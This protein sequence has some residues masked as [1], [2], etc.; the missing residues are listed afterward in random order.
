MRSVDSCPTAQEC[1][2]LNI[3]HIEAGRYLYGGAAQVL[4]LLKGLRER[5]GRQVLICAQGSAI[6]ET[7]RSVAD[8][9]YAV[10][11][12]GDADVGL[13]P[14]VRSILRCERADLVHLH[15]RRGADIWGALAARSCGLP[16][17]L[18]RRVDHPEP[19]WLAPW[20]YRLYDR[21]IA[22]SQGIRQ[23]LVQHGAVS[24]QQV[25]CVCSAVDTERFKPTGDHVWFRQEFNLAADELTVAMSA[26]F[27]ARKGHREFVLAMPKILQQQPSTR[28]LLFGQGPLQADIEALC[29]QQGVRERVIFAGF[30]IDMDKILP[31]VTLLVHPAK[32]E[33]LGVAFTGSRCLCAP[34]CRRPCRWY[35]GDRS[36]WLERS[37]D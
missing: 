23:V 7:A 2:G 34:D 21:V 5:S 1:Y 30:R 25:V 20:K 36:P 33:G 15:S 9:V 28:F 22:I 8:Q 35:T 26:Q 17:V 32:K 16:T 6:A 27:I 24:E 12:K 10:P 37:A 19:R 18:S 3:V 14:R 4:M 31:C 13:V 11:M 29:D